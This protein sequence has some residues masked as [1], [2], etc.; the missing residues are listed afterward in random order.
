MGKVVQNVKNGFK[1]AFTAR[2]VHGMRHQLA[3]RNPADPNCPHPTIRTSE[4]SFVL[5]RPTLPSSSPLDQTPHWTYTIELMY[6]RVEILGFT[7]ESIHDYFQ[8]A[9]STQ[10]SSDEVKD[11]IMKLRD[12]FLKIPSH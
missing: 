11:E 7:K 4:N 1:I 8:E 3:L 9:L 10:L 5:F 2:W 6:N 12:H